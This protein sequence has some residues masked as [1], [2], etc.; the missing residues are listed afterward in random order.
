MAIARENDN[1]KGTSVP[2]SYGHYIGIASGQ[3]KPVVEYE[4]IEPAQGR[5]EAGIEQH[6]IRK[7]SELAF[8]APVKSDWLG[9]I[10]T[11]IFGS[12]S[13]NEA[14]GETA[15]FDH[16]I[17]VA[18]NSTPP[19]YSLYMLDDVQS[20][21]ATYGI[22]KK[23]ELTCNAD[24][25]LNA[26]VEVIAQA[27]ESGSGTAAYS[28]DHHFQGSHLTVKIAADLA[29]LGAASAVNFQTMKLTI[30]REV[31]PV[32][33]FGST[34]P[35]KFVAGAIKISGELSIVYENTTQRGYY[36][37]ETDKA[38]RLDFNDSATT[39]GSAETPQLLIDLAKI[40]FIS[41]ERPDG[42]DEA[43]IET[44]EFEA[45]YDLD[46]TSPKMVTITLTNEEA[47]YAYGSEFG[48]NESES[49]TVAESVSMAVS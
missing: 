19:A 30:E 41:H 18:N 36:E 28:T 48:I 33:A 38:L 11:G 22:I 7:Y 8:S 42:I 21:L 31:T 47:E 39:I 44:M 45:S 26:D 20:D 29:S 13:S 15:I 6:I 40:N 35:N 2:A 23:L 49:I 25:I 46:E 17:T 24:G 34:E 27:R 1:A 37:G 4:K 10:L 12:V 32:Y 14:S 43:D 16:T 9:H 5:I 3:L